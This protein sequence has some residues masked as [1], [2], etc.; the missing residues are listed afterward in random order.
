MMNGCVGGGGHFKC[1]FIFGL[2][3]CFAHGHFVHF[4][5]SLSLCRVPALVCHSRGNSNNVF[6]LVYGFKNDHVY[7]SQCNISMLIC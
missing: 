2:T 4:G 6:L 5:R 3:W 1:I 7:L